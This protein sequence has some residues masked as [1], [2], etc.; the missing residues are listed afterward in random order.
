MLADFG[1]EV[2]KVEYV[3]RL[4][5]LRGGRKDDRAYDKHPGWLQVNR[6]KLSVTLDLEVEK[7][8][9]VYRDLVKTSDV[10]IENARTGVMDK[11]G[12]GYEDLT[13]IKKDLIVLSMTAFGNTG[14]YSSYAGYGAIF[15]AVGGIQ[16][17]TAYEK[18]E[19]PSRIKELDIT[20]GLAGACACQTAL[21]YRQRTG[22]GQYIDMSQLE[23]AT[24][25]L[26]GEHMLEYMMNGTGSLPIGNH[27]RIFAPQGCYRCKGEDK[28]V[29]ITVRSDEE[30]QSLCDVLDHPE[31]ASDARF[32]TAEAR[33]KNH[34]EIDRMIEDWTI[35]HV[36]HDVMNLLQDGGIPAGAVLNTEEIKNDRHLKERNYFI[37]EESSPGSLFMGLPFKF[38]SGAGRIKWHG[39]ALGQHN[40]QVLCELLGRPG[41]AVEPVH[42]EEILTAFD[43]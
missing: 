6:N 4:C 3:R 33:M 1:A 39:P 31:W 23:A 37:R 16:S 28:W 7:D 40:K 34:A 24:H 11:L 12:F 18:G 19:K 10:L 17:L 5:L 30:W 38:S 26:A 15:E 42:E 25:A 8:R 2:I 22:R 32:L 41:E 14:P 21:L 9:E 35:S 36:H 20:N 13:K 43:P 27:H 29:T